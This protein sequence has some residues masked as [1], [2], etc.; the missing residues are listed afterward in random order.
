MPPSC[1][2]DSAREKKVQAVKARAIESLRDQNAKYECGDAP[3]PEVN[4]P[5]LK[6]A[7]SSMIPRSKGM[8][9]SEF[10]ALWESALG[11]IQAADEV[12]TGTE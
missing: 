4:E 11:E 1:E 7:I 12:T 8:T 2:P 6:K 9:N 3:K 10:E 5:E